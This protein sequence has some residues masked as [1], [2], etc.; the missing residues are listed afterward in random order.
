[1]TSIEDLLPNKNLEDVFDLKAVEIMKRITDILSIATIMLSV[2]VIYVVITVTPKYMH[3]LK[4]YLLFYVLSGLSEKL[5]AALFKPFVIFPY[6]IFYP[7]GW[8]A[9]MSH[10]MV[11]V[12]SPS[13]YVVTFLL[14][15][16]LLMLLIDRYFAMTVTHPE[17]APFYKKKLFYLFLCLTVSTVACA[18]DFYANLC[19]DQYNYGEVTA[20]FMLRKISGSQKL[21][22]YQPDLLSFNLSNTA[23]QTL[24]GYAVMG[25]GGFFL[26]LFTVFIFLNIIAAK[27][28][29]NFVS[30]RS[31][32]NHNM[33]IRM[34]YA[35]I[36]GLL[37]FIFLP[38][39][40]FFTVSGYFANASYLFAVGL[41]I[42]EFFLLYDIGV[43]VFFIRPYRIFMVDL[44]CRWT[45]EHG[46]FL[47]PSRASDAA[48]KINTIFRRK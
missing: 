17:S 26:V 10:T 1:M 46:F 6:G 35:Q 24:T 38:Q 7:V 23:P 29:I 31:R 15:T 5:L 36:V 20:Q 8:L 47:K 22:D 19:M 25:G 18:I 43:T 39:I 40:A 48:T 30:V 32:R 4:P 12:L 42:Q 3:G 34:T 21:L 14:L 33:L 41:T 9:P 16:S 44:F 11:Q 2:F 28:A 27:K 13:T 45:N 37:A